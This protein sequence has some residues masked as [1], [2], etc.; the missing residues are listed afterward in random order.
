MRLKHWQ[1]RIK[2]TGILFQ[3]I[4]VRVAKVTLLAL[5]SRKIISIAFI[6]SLIAGNPL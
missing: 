2:P 4:Q 5:F 3:G 6:K 1:T